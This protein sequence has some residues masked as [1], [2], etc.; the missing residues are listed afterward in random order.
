[1]KFSPIQHIVESAHLGRSNGVYVAALTIYLD[2]SGTS[3]T[4]SI[5]V[6]AGWIAKLPSW[7]LFQR[8]WE[9]IKNIESDKFGCMHMAEFVHGSEEFEGWDLDKKLR[10][11]RKLRKVIMKR[12]LKG[13]AL[14]VIKK[15]FDEVVPDELRKLGFENHYTFAVRSVLGMIDKWRQEKGFQ[16]APIEYIFDWQDRHDLRRKEI[17]EVFARAKGDDNA[18]RRYGIRENDPLFRKKDSI[19]P[20]QA[21]DILAWSV[22]QVVLHEIEKTKLKP[23]AKETFLDFFS[24]RQRGFLEGGYNKRQAIIEWVKSKGFAPSTI[25]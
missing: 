24:H 19:Y 25:T 6:A 13:F 22:Y 23:I 5:A 12:A 9:K 1:M 15:D 18:F 16:D 8:D 14:G 20:L 11:I 21:A 10:V 3:P 7:E 17:E 2:D 4:N